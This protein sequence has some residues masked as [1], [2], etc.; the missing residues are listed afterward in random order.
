MCEQK[1]KKIETRTTKASPNDP[2]QK[3]VHIMELDDEN[4]P[5]KG[6]QAYVMGYGIEEGMR[7][8]ALTDEHGRTTFETIITKKDNFHVFKLIVAGMAGNGTSF[9]VYHGREE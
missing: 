2:D 6:I 8:L 4:R 1:P 7:P 3:I 9:D 5:V